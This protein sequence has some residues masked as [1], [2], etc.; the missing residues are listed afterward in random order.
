R[1]RGK[2]FLPPGGKVP[3]MQRDLCSLTLL[4]LVFGGAS[5][6]RCQFMYFSN[7][8]PGEIRSANLDASGQVTLVTDLAGPE[9][10][11]LDLAGGQ[12]YWSEIFASDIRHDHRRALRCTGLS[13]CVPNGRM[14]GACRLTRRFG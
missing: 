9:G 14:D 1:S 8:G 3:A 7:S 2:V 10:P 12:M 4:V 13:R 6:A 11:V 5:P